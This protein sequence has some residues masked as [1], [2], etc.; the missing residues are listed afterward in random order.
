MLKEKVKEELDRYSD[1]YK[2][3][4]NADV[5]L[6]QEHVGSLW[7]KIFYIS[8]VEFTTDLIKFKKENGYVRKD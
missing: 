8:D 1:F 7:N 2:K 4:Y 5:T 3:Y 6:R